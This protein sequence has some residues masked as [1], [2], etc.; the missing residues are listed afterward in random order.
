MHFASHVKRSQVHYMRCGVEWS[1]NP[2]GKYR[3]QMQAGWITHTHTQRAG[4]ETEY[5]SDVL[6][7]GWRAIVFSF[8]LPFQWKLELAVR[9]LHKLNELWFCH[10]PA[11][12][13]EWEEEHF[14]P[15]IKVLYC[16]CHKDSMSEEVQGVCRSSRCMKPPVESYWVP[17]PT[18]AG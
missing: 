11:M 10:G 12:N 7:W 15:N 18:S 17:T 5:R 14:T 13:H 16:L 8:E 1:V 3:S 4:L 2:S 9:Q 6:F